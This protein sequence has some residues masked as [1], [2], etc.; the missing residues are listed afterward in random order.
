MND[1]E[2]NP[3][4]NMAEEKQV[5]VRVRAFQYNGGAGVAEQ[6]EEFL[7]GPGRD[8][9]ALSYAVERDQSRL[10]VKHY[11]LLTFSEDQSS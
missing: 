3:P 10:N 2:R 9:L 5:E 1:G 8:F 6:V 4:L 7:S 11:A